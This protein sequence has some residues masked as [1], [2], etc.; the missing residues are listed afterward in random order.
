MRGFLLRVATFTPLDQKVQNDV[1]K[2]CR[3]EEGTLVVA[4]SNCETKSIGNNV[5]GLLRYAHVRMRLPV[6]IWKVR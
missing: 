4:M 6:P 3:A 2:P 5:T 1:S